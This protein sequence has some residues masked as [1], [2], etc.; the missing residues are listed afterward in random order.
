MQGKWRQTGG[1]EGWEP[2]PG[3]PAA[4]LQALYD[5]GMAEPTVEGRHEIVWQAI[6]IHI[7]DG[8]FTLGAAG[9]Q[10]MPVVVKD[11]VHNV[12]EF[13]ILGPWAPGSPGNTNPSQYWIE[14]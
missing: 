14:Q 2:E 6:R 8:P 9:D 7:E 5:E 10:P 4:R 11:N 12:P 3:S 13:G 1:A